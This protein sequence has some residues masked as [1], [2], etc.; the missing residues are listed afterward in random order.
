MPYVDWDFEKKESHKDFTG[1]HAKIALKV[2]SKNKF[3]FCT[4]FTLLYCFATHP[5]NNC[6]IPIS[7]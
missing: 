3:T 6:F 1:V 5:M 4:L 2:K 7:L